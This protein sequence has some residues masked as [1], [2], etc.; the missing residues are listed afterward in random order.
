V[1]QVPAVVVV[2][3]ACRDLVDDDPRGWRLGGG[4]VYSALALAR[5][6]LSVGAF[7]VA[8]DLADG[9]EELAQIRDAGVEVVRQPG[10][11]G[12]VFVNVE[13]P[14][15]R[16]QRTPQVSDACDPAFLPPRWRHAGAWMLAP[17]A[18]E[19]PEPWAMVPRPDALVGLG[20][21]GMLRVLRPGE[22]VRHLPP[23][24]SQVVR[25]ADLVGVGRDDFDGD[26]T[27]VDD[28]VSHLHP[29]ARLLVTDGARGGEAID[30]ADR[31]VPG[32][33]RAWRSLPVTRYVDPVGA[34]DTFLAGVFAALLEPGLVRGWDGPD[35]ELRLGAACASLVVEGSGI[36]AVPHRADAIAR[37]HVGDGEDAPG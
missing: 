24:A 28:L 36:A 6:G 1:E 25:R 20:W 27:T 18:A 5:L 35:P 12:P 26:A 31:S 10:S 29:G 3:A 23:A 37:M 11:R 9:S 17:V 19:I 7:I 30:V 4:A 32:R 22:A 15:G 16:V 8:D 33:R 21:Q 13:T 34:G 14:R 2:G